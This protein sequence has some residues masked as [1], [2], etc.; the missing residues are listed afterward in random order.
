[1][2]SIMDRA[3]RY[4]SERSASEDE[5][6]LYLE[7]EFEAIPN[8]NYR[9]DL[10]LSRLKELHLIDDMQL[11]K[12]LAQHYVHKG[13]RFI[14]QTLMQK[15]ISKEITAHVLLA[16]DN[17]HVRALNEARKKLAGNWDSSQKAMTLLHRF[18]SG[19]SFSHTTIKNVM[20]N[21][22]AQSSFL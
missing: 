7:K 6:R 22:A 12:K 10:A 2:S 15:G 16:L 20:S 8:M 4:L 13:N 17:E 11:A 1:M 19:R 9:I 3:I 18:L 21:L 14:Y 5:V